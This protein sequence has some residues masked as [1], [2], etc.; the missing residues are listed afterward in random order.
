MLDCS[1]LR[2]A[3]YSI[4]WYC[5][6][7]IVAGVIEMFLVIQLHFGLE[8][9]LLWHKS[10]FLGQ[11]LALLWTCRTARFYLE[12]KLQRRLCDY[13][14]ARSAEFHRLTLRLRWSSTLGNYWEIVRCLFLGTE[15]I[16][17]K[18]FPDWFI[19]G[20]LNFVRPF[21]RLLL[22]FGVYGTLVLMS[23]S[24]AISKCLILS[25]NRTI[26]LRGP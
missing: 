22:N 6:Q 18:L 17:S 19:F 7:R 4:V 9:G 26:Y 2:V 5:W 8:L 24:G 15:L 11:R 1:G 20:A 10:S 25:R 14:S 21:L 23:A 13:E 12:L 3:T 16:I